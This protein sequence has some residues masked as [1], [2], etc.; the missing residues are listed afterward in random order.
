MKKKAIQLS[1]AA[2]ATALMVA[3]A[4]L[5]YPFFS[6][7]EIT[8]SDNSI[9]IRVNNQ[10]S[11]TPTTSVK[12]ALYFTFNS[13]TLL[14]SLNASNQTLLAVLK[15]IADSLQVELLI[16]TSLTQMMN[17]PL[18]VSIVDDDVDNILDTILPSTIYTF[19][20]IN[21]PENLMPSTFLCIGHVD[22]P[23]N[24]TDNDIEMSDSNTGK[25]NDLSNKAVT[26]YPFDITRPSESANDYFINIRENFYFSDEPERIAMLRYLDAEN[27][28]VELL[29]NIIR[30]DDSAAVRQA[31]VRK[32][33][34]SNNPQAAEALLD[35]LSDPNIAVVASAIN[36]LNDTSFEQYRNEIPNRLTTTSQEIRYL[37]REFN[38]IDNQNYEESYN[39]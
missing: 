22:C 19:Q 17:T 20:K 6:S 15:K 28:D 26:L 38:L 39:K 24:L 12:E 34:F 7:E 37:L 14:G 13:Q 16:D 1:F 5:Y 36:V 11:Q 18:T 10:T 33:A 4:H 2:L 30:T 32:F 25:T 3:G 23:E 9:S 8:K 31:A 21:L 35:A 27:D 29:V